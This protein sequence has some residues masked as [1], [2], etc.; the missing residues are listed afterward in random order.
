MSMHSA[1]IMAQRI[2]YDSNNGARVYIGLWCRQRAESECTK[3]AHECMCECV[4]SL[5]VVP[6]NINAGTIT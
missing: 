4:R 1:N 3:C 6:N 2:C 5:I